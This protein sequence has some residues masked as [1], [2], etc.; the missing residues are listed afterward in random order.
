MLIMV[1]NATGI[2][3]GLLAGKYPGRIGHLFSPGGQRGPWAELPY[4]LD[5][6]AWPAFKNKTPWNE[7][8][9]RHLLAWAAMSGQQ[10]LWALVPDVVG[11]RNG[12][13]LNWD[14]YEGVVAGYGFRR[15]FAVQNDMTFDDVPDGDCMLFLGGDDDW[16]DAAIGPWCARF[17]GRVHVGRVTYWY[18]LAACW[19]A[20]AAS[21]DGNGWFQKGRTIGS[22][23]FNDLR[24]F[25][26]ETQGETCEPRSARS[27][28]STPR[29]DSTDCPPT[30]SATDSTG[31]PTAS[32]S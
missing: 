26:R 6:G 20:G 30:T 25:L 1:S 21:I 11:D 12:T 19:K 10:P 18:R 24:K 14:K 7:A 17:P 28:P 31:T 2:E 27:S 13:L 23:Q 16:K 32:S 8:E 5:N 15:A 29:T 9:W 4:A 3:V 22:S